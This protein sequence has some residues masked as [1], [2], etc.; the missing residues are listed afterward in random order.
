MKFIVPI[1]FFMATPLMAQ[2]LLD[3]VSEIVSEHYPE[4]KMQREGD[5]YTFAHATRPFMVHG[6]SMTGQVS[7]SAREVVGPSYTGFI[8]RLDYHDKNQ[9]YQ[10]ELPQLL[11]KPYWST[12]IIRFDIEADKKHYFIS[13]S[14]GSRLDEA[15]RKKIF[16]ILNE[17]NK[18]VEPTS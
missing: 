5:V 9:V 17:Q 3:R 11:N 18:P 13:F 12:Y 2:S 10:P 14:Y 1:L 7:E 6:R 15:F 4:V 16:E 8:L